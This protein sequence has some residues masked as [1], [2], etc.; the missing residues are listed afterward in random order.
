MA[1]AAQHRANCIRSSCL[2]SV[3]ITNHHPTPCA[4]WALVLSQAMAAG[5]CACKLLLLLLPWP[6]ELHSVSRPASTTTGNNPSPFRCQVLFWLHMPDAH[7]GCAHWLHTLP[8]PPRSSQGCHTLLQQVAY[9][10]R[11]TPPPGWLRIFAA[12]AAAAAATGALTGLSHPA[13]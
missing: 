10:T 9:V 13:L 8:L 7:A 3:M 12:Y 2:A 5:C 4:M 11:P 6:Q 1:Q